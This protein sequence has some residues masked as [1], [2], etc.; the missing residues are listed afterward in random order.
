[1]R[2]E[3]GL[4]LASGVHDASLERPAGHGAV[5]VVELDGLRGGVRD[6]ENRG[7]LPEILGFP[8]HD[9]Y[10]SRRED[11]EPVSGLIDLSHGF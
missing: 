2:R 10:V 8:W 11:L 7:V 1:M 9:A 3:L 5:L 4:P 6:P